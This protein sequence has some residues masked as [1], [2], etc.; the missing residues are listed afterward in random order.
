[1]SLAIHILATFLVA[2]WVIRQGKIHSIL[3]RGL[4]ALF[5]WLL[6]PTAWH[7]LVAAIGLP[8]L[9]FS[10]WL[11]ILGGTAVVLWLGHAR[12]DHQRKS[13]LPKPQETSHKRR[14]D[15]E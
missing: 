7:H 6:L 9:P 3:A 5:C 13:V 1:M 2:G 11:V 10:G 15:A 14:L 4:T 8:D 12:F